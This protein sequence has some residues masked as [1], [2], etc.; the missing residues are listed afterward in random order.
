MVRSML[1]NYGLAH[2]E[3][4]MGA[5]PLNIPDTIL[6]R[7]VRTFKYIIFQ[8]FNKTF[9]KRFSTIFKKG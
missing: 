3:L 2:R 1:E 9:M 8:S 6:P 7:I 4:F 5:S